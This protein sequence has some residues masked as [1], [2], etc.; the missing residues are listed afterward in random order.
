MLSGYDAVRIS[1]P[2]QERD[3]ERLDDKTTL[4]STFW[5]R[6]GHTFY[7]ISCPL[8]TWVCDTS[9]SPPRWHRRE[10]YGLDFW[11]VSCVEAFN[12][13]LIAGDATTGKLYEMS[14]EFYDDAG[15]PLISRVQFAPTH[16]FPYRLTVNEMFFDVEVGVGSGQGNP[17]DID[18][19]AMVALSRD[20][21]E[22]FTTE[23]TLS[24]GKQGQRLTRVRTRRLGQFGQNGFVAALSWSGKFARALYQASADVTRNNA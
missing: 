10:T 5:T 6:N 20:G 13:K 2:A 8:F 11:N 16:A 17:Q 3:I 21:G 9:T 23:R 22:T 24:L 1:T 15:L 19:Y 7:M 4:V 18:P 12:G 14:P